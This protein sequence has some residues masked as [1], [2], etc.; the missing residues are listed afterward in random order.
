M[1]QSSTSHFQHPRQ[2]SQNYA[3]C[4]NGYRQN[5]YQ[6]SINNSFLRCG[7]FMA[8]SR[9]FKRIKTRKRVNL[10]RSYQ[11]WLVQQ[12]VLKC[13]KR[14]VA[15]VVNMLVTERLSYLFHYLP[16]FF[17]FKVLRHK[18]VITLKISMLAHLPDDD[19]VC[20]LRSFIQ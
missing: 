2:P 12:K 8:Y 10:H 4:V 13:D 6:V 5:S 19:C 11:V 16:Y 7:I 1:I 18:N 15:Y 9:I 20:F 14:K 17:L 3:H